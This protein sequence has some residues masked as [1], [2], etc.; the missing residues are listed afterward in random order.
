[1][2]ALPDP[3]TLPAAQ[4]P[5]PELWTA[6]V[7]RS[8]WRRLAVALSGAQSEPSIGIARQACI[9]C[10][11]DVPASQSRGLHALLASAT[12][13]SE[14]WHLRPEV[15]RVLALHTTQA[16]AESRLAATRCHF[17]WR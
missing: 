10:L 12:T 16:E 3:A 8:G 5:T 7:P 14:L 11:A 17:K 13:L 15:Y 9:A 4:G 2:H 6:S 1:M